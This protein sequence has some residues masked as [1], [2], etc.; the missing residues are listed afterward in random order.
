MAFGTARV[1]G[2]TAFKSAASTSPSLDGHPQSFSHLTSLAY[3]VRR[4][5]TAQ[6]RRHFGPIML[7]KPLS[8]LDM[9]LFQITGKG[10]AFFAAHH[11]AEKQK[12]AAAAAASPSSSL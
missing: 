4:L 5:A 8:V 3:Q 2:R 7:D 6:L 10:K 11:K 1:F 9:P 12:L